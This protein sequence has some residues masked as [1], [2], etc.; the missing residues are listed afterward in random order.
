MD[1]DQVF[2]FRSYQVANEEIVWKM[3]WIAFIYFIG[4]IPACLAALY[5]IVIEKRSYEKRKIEENRTY[6]PPWSPDEF[7]IFILFF[8]VLIWP[9]AILLFSGGFILYHILEFLKR[10]FIQLINWLDRLL[11]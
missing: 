7:L 4:L 5:V 8:L 9:G 2:N 11:P 6:L 10:R 3:N 1:V